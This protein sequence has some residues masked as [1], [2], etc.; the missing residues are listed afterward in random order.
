[1]AALFGV[2]DENKGGTVDVGELVGKWVNIRAT[3]KFV[4]QSSIDEIKAVLSKVDTT[5]EGE[6][7]RTEFVE[8]IDVCRV[9]D[10]QKQGIEATHPM[11]EDPHS[12]LEDADDDAAAL[13]AKLEADEAARRLKLNSVKWG[14]AA[15]GSRDKPE[16][17]ISATEAKMNEL[18]EIAASAEAH[19]KLLAAQVREQEEAV[20]AA[21]AKMAEAQHESSQLSKAKTA[22][23]SDVLRPQFVRLFREIDYACSSTVP[24]QCLEDSLNKLG[25]KIAAGHWAEELDEAHFVELLQNSFA[26]HG[27]DTKHLLMK[28]QQVPFYGSPKRDKKAELEARQLAA[29]HR[30][31]AAS[32]EQQQAQHEL[33][34]ALD[35]IKT[36]PKN[37]EGPPS[38]K[39]QIT[40]GPLTT[41]PS[42]P[43]RP[44][45]QDEIDNLPKASYFKLNPLFDDPL[46]HE[47]VQLEIS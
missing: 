21:K 1:L 8:F 30:L 28:L 45:T 42:V 14:S 23:S 36:P 2:L 20:A 16:E 40:G 3:M 27:G 7:N 13:V 11:L 32:E 44:A 31:N 38:P 25:C 24:R 33:N 43:S 4:F 37:Q 26:A 15:A 18:M 19:T 22:L 46:L 9:L 6:L 34:L 39:S 29:E 12:V 5:G 47:V 10:L 41:A 35:G 17:E